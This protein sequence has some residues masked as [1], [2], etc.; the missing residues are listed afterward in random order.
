MSTPYPEDALTPQQ[1]IA[2]AT[3]AGL[4]LATA[5]LAAEDMSE[6]RAAAYANAT[7]L[8][9]VAIQAAQTLLQEPSAQVQAQLVEL[10]HELAERVSAL[11]ARHEQ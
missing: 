10:S 2:R 3:G 9:E 11:E 4:A 1:L 8:A 7:R 6:H 5:S